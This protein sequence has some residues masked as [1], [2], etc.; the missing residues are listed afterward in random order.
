[1]DEVGLRLEELLNKLKTSQLRLALDTGLNQSFLSAI[2]RGKKNISRD[3]LF[4]I[5]SKY[6]MV[7]LTWL[8]TGNGTMFL[9]DQSEKVDM[10][11][12]DFA[13]LYQASKIHVLKIAIGDDNELRKTLGSNLVRLANAWGMKKNE[14]FG[15]LMPGVKKQSV[16]NYFHGA[17]QPPLGVLINIERLSGIG[18]SAWL[19]RTID[20]NELPNEPLHEGI[21]SEDQIQT[22][23]LSIYLFMP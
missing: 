14:L 7:N 20:A 10:V 15:M 6:P 2:I 17:S 5:V 22:K 12:E 18:I 3:V 4:S 21:Q 1:M 11:A 9:P 8:L 16:T 13:S 23:Y 19:T